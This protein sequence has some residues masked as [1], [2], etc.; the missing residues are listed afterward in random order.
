MVSWFHL[1]TIMVLVQIHLSRGANEDCMVAVYNVEVVESCPTSKQEW[2]I[3]ARRKN[4]SYLAAEAER[5][6]CVMNEKQPK[7]HCLI[8]ALR[9]KFLEVCAPEKTIFGYCTE[10]NEAGKVIQNHY[11]ALCEDVS[12]KCDAIYRSSDAYKY[13]GCYGLV[14]KRRVS[15][16]VESGDSEIGKNKMIIFMPTVF[17]I[18]WCLVT[19]TAVLYFRR[20]QEKGKRKK[21]A[22]EGHDFLP[23]TT[24]KGADLKPSIQYYLCNIRKF[25][26][27]HYFQKRITEC[28]KRVMEKD[29]NSNDLTNI[30]T[31]NGFVIIGVIGE[32]TAEDLLLFPKGKAIKDDENKTHWEAVPLLCFQNNFP[33]QSMVET[34][35]KESAC[36]LILVKPVQDVA[37]NADD[38]IIVVDRNKENVLEALTSCLEQPLCNMLQEWLH[39][40][41]EDPVILGEVEALYK[42]RLNPNNA[43]DPTKVPDD[44]KIYLSRRFDVEAYSMVTNSLLK[45]FVQKSTDEEEL[46]NDLEELNPKFFTKCR[47]QIEKGKFTKKNTGSFVKKYDDDRNL[48]TPTLQNK[49][50]LL[51]RK[52]EVFPVQFRKARR[53]KVY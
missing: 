42:T 46:Q 24:N 36:H 37:D 15:I 5:K 41:S 14:N 17:V 12:P 8:N 6:N 52:I 26:H 43:I 23:K 30:V 47:L 53:R 31:K 33:L 18:V 7:Y 49:M 3:A 35:H 9:N 25:E 44:L 34:C 51:T 28:K 48:V 38:S 11:A 1:S 16:D 27:L 45:V 10:F 22:E 39:L 13:T 2:D 50:K 32:F 29:I 4:C 19:V 20:K 40:Y 21:D